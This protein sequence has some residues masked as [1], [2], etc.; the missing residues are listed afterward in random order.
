[1]GK[2]SGLWFCC[3]AFFCEGST[4]RFAPSDHATSVAFLICS[5]PPATRRTR[6]ACISSFPFSF[7][8]VKKKWMFTLIQMKSFAMDESLSSMAQDHPIFTA[9]S[10]WKV[11][12][13]RQKHG[14]MEFRKPAFLFCFSRIIV[15]S[16][17]SSL[18]NLFSFLLLLKQANKELGGG[19]QGIRLDIFAT[20]T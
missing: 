18:C 9:I 16:A 10:T 19:C 13:F 20:E 11:S 14:R 1:M 8:T 5:S 7:W 4:C 12:E 2:L 17:L 15:S 3:T 6:A